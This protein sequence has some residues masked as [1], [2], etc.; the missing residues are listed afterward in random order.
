MK[1][2]DNRARAEGLI[3]RIGSILG[4]FCWA[5]SA[6]AVANGSLSGTVS[7]PSGGVIQGA[8]ITLVNVALKSTYTSASN[9]QGYYSFPTLP[10]GHYNMTIEAAGFTSQKKT[11]VKID[12]DSAVTVDTI[13][14]LGQ[15]SEQV[16]V[17]SSDS[18]IDTVAT[19]LGEIVTGTEMTALP[20]NGRSF[21]DLLSIQPGI[22][23]ITTL[24]PSS[25]IMA[26]VTGTISPSG[27]LN[28]GN[29]SIDGQR[30]SSNG[31]MVDGIDVQEHMNG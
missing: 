30:E 11:D 28:P 15:L 3:R 8:T 24:T 26:G 22:I 14:Q 2:P 27:D 21:T 19:H 23:P 31:F 18:Q 9:V 12:T 6:L 4:F 7:D 5:V 17:Q 1:S 10:V 16:I 25:V 13:L 29:L 20:L